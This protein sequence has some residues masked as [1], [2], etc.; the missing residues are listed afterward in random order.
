LDKKAETSKLSPNKLA[1]KN[2]IDDT[3]TTILREELIHLFQRVKVKHLLE[4]D[5]N[6]K[7][8]HLVANGKHQKQKKLQP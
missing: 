8:F 5:N 6:T 1:L 4:E 7:Y 3:L 2:Y